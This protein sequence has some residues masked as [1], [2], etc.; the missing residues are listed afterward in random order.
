MKQMILQMVQR[1]SVDVSRQ[2]RL[3]LAQVAPAAT[4]T[5]LDLGCGAKPYQAIFSKVQLYV[6][7][8]LPCELS[9]NK[10]NKR[11]DAYADLLN[12]PFSNSSFDVVLSTQALEHSADPERALRE[13]A[14]V[15]RGNG[16]III[17]VPFLAAEHEEPHDYFR[18]T[19]FGVSALLER[20][21]FR[22]VAVRKQFGFW[23][24]IGEM[25]YWH[26][27]RKVQ[28]GRLEK[29]WY[30]FGTTLFLRAFRLLDR[31]DPDDKLMLN[32]CITAQRQSHETLGTA[33]AVAAR[34]A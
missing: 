27:H 1:L 7:V 25:I 26:F 16:L 20:S 21:G 15:L 14:R 4:G 3:D 6:G 22:N 8:D 19:R 10:L 23:L 32:L 30:A 18:Y 13:A 2:I 24:T 17:T 34:Q 31:A 9:A 5:L 33:R 29:Y 28:G 12:L 11:A